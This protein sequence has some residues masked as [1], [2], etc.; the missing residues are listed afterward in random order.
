LHC[1][2]SI[3]RGATQA[4]DGRMA[5]NTK[6]ATRILVPVVD[7]ANALPAARYLARQVLA[8]EQCEVHLLHLRSSLSLSVERLLTG[9]NREVLHRRSAEEALRPVRQFMDER[10]IPYTVHLRVG[11]PEDELE[12]AARELAVDRIVMGTARRWSP[13]ERFGVSV[14]VGA[15]FWVLLELWAA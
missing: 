12:P 13:T 3:F 2:C 5:A 1:Q 15:A 7:A 8:G 9:E 6:R 4:Q 10:R 11:D 14:G